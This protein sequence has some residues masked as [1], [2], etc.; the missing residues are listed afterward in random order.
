M[1]KFIFETQNG[2]TNFRQ[3]VQNIVEYAEDTEV[4][5]ARLVLIIDSAAWQ[6]S[7]KLLALKFGLHWMFGENTGETFGN[8]K[9]T[10]N[11]VSLLRLKDKKFLDAFRTDSNTELLITDM[12]EELEE[13]YLKYPEYRGRN[14]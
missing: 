6:Y 14:Y 13:F 10:D 2:D 4:L 3:A 1:K 12:Y 7:E 5:K 8:L 9:D 11:C